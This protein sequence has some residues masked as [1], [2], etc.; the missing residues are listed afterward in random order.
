MGMLCGLEE[1]NADLGGIM[2]LEHR[3]PDATA[4]VV[5]RLA[6]SRRERQAL[7][8]VRGR[9]ENGHDCAHTQS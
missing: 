6:F 3:Q 5:P 8:H 4:G 2:E 7:N 9:V 1:H